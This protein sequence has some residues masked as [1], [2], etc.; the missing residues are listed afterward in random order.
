MTSCQIIAMLTL[1]STHLC[2]SSKQVSEANK[3]HS[4]YVLGPP[5]KPIF[6]LNTVASTGIR[7]IRHCHRRYSRSSDTLR[8]P[9]GSANEHTYWRCWPHLHA[10]AYRFALRYQCSPLRQ[11]FGTLGRHCHNLHLLRDPG[12]D[13]GNQ[14]QGVGSRDPTS[15]HS[16]TS[17]EPSIRYVSLLPD[18]LQVCLCA[19]L[20]MLDSIQLDV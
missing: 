17:Y 5:Q 14:Y 18:C 10:N 9:M 8:R 11:W 12:C 7:S 4:W 19:L 6:V 2:S 16:G 15:S 13:L 1:P 20:L 3:L